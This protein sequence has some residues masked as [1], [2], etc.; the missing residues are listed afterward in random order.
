MLSELKAMILKL[1]S[2]KGTSEFIRP[3]MINFQSFKRNFV[4]VSKHIIIINEV[5]I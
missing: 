4:K 2:L 5:L 1:N 3:S